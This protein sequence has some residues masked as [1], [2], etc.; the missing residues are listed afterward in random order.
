MLPQNAAPECPFSGSTG[1]QFFV[2]FLLT[3]CPPLC[4]SEIDE[5]ELPAKSQ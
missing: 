1:I 2:D 5:E 4:Y 3:E